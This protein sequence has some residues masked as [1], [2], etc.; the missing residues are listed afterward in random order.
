MKD[1]IDFVL[2]TVCACSKSRQLGIMYRRMLFPIYAI[3]RMREY[4]PVLMSKKDIQYIY[5]KFEYS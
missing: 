5:M 4:W 3:K 1:D 2:D